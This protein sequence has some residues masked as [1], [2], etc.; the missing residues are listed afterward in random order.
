MNISTN[1][2]EAFS[3]GVIAIVITIMVFKIRFPLTGNFTGKQEIAA[4]IR[5][6]PQIVAYF[7]SFLILG[8]MWINHHH[9]MHMIQH[10]NEKF[11]WLNLHFLFWLSLIPFPTDM[12]GL[13]PVLHESTAIYG[14]ILFMT[15]FAFSILRTYAIR[16]GLMY[17]DEKVLDKTLDRVNRR[18][19]R[20]DYMGMA[21]Y[22]LSV[23]LSYYSVYLAYACFIVLPVLFFIPEGI[24]DEELAEKL[25]EDNME[26][27]KET[28]V[29]AAN[30]IA[31]AEELDESK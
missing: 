6:V 3:D 17:R 5:M 21:A 28:I 4:L 1:R 30:N 20:K 26:V 23:P 31:P 22:F 9:V 16:H 13:N 2:V 18:A 24:E 10:V 19:K 12:L 25:I 29:D 27:A 8:I 14:G 7:F 11:L 15:A